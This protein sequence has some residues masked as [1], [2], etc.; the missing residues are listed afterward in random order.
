MMIVHR[1]AE[2]LDV[3]LALRAAG[4]FSRLLNGWE[5]ERDK[6]A[7]NGDDDEELDE[8]KS[9]PW[10]LVVYH[11]DSADMRIVGGPSHDSSGGSALSKMSNRAEG[12]S[13]S[14]DWQFRLFKRPKRQFLRRYSGEIC[15]RSP[16]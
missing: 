2:L 3:V 15:A 5:Q 14:K 13:P 12:G 7:N 16:V 4:S 9:T 10:R 1:K 6:D 8:R 11:L